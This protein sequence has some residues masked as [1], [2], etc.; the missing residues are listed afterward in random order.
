MT[1]Q[2]TNEKTAWAIRQPRRFG[3]LLVLLSLLTLLLLPAAEAF[4]ARAADSAASSGAKKSSAKKAGAKK[5]TSKKRTVKKRTTNKRTVK[6]RTVKQR[7]AKK[8]SSSKERVSK[9]SSRKQVHARKARL[10]QAPPRP[11][12][13]AMQAGLHEVADDLHLKASVAFVMDQDTHKVL[14]GKNASAVLPIA[15]L[16]K[17]MTGVIVTDAK[18]PMD[19]KLT[20]TRADV[21]HLKGSS[22]RLRVGTVLTRRQ[23]LHLALMSSENRAAHALART[24][25]GGEEAFVSAMNVKA[26]KLG[27][28]DTRYV[29]PTGLSS[30]NQSTARD[31]ALLADAAYERPL[32]R[33]YTTSTGYQLATRSGTLQYNNTNRLVKDP[34][35]DIGLQKTGFI[36]EAGQCLLMQTEMAGRNL[37]MVFLDSASRLARIRDAERVRA[38]LEKQPALAH[39]PASQEL[40]P[41]S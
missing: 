15:S 27:M 39:T 13:Y 28:V 14:L 12:S 30:D 25:P 22:S 29:E 21:D 17:L 34:D 7:V 9:R 19:E 24:Y 4:A 5:R 16:T 1:S 31:L 8:R 18:L 36:S 2:T 23:A 32:L 35:W 33:K 20:I 10:R 38:W 41:A 37:I 3:W 40:E 6:K 11:V 26:R